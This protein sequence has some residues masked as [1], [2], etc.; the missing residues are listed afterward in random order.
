MANLEGSLEGCSPCR[1]LIRWSFGGTLS[2]SQGIVN[3]GSGAIKRIRSLRERLLATAVLTDL[4]PQSS[5]AIHALAIT[6]MTTRPAA[7][8]IESGMSTA[9]WYVRKPQRPSKT[10]V[11]A[12]RTRATTTT[13]GALKADGFMTVFSKNLD[14][15]AVLWESFPSCRGD[16]TGLARLNGL[17]ESHSSQMVF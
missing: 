5:P 3:Q 1:M 9:S 12:T 17:P 7:E 13:A 4:Q 16:H 10:R 8:A 6:V 2:K 14:Y 11:S 15:Q